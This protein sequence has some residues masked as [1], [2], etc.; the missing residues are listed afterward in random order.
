[1]RSRKRPFRSV[2]A[3][4]ARLNYQPE[5]VQSA[6]LRSTSHNV[7]ST[8]LARDA[9]ADASVATDLRVGDPAAFFAGEQSG[10]ACNVARLA[11]AQRRALLKAVLEFLGQIAKQLRS[12]RRPAKCS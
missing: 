1:M 6:S 11:D 7:R 5:H 12:L 8:E 4:S 3:L 10:D 2:A 9:L